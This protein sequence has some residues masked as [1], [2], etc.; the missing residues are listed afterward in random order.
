MRL[1]PFF[2]SGTPTYQNPSSYVGPAVPNAPAQWFANW[3]T[4]PEV[5]GDLQQSI[6]D[7]GEDV[8]DV[9]TAAADLFSKGSEAIDRLKDYIFPESDQ[10]SAGGFRPSTSDLFDYYYADLSKLYG[11]DKNTAFQEALSNTAYQ[12]AVKDMQAAGLNPASLFGGSRANSANGV[13]FIGNSGSSFGS[14][15]SN[16][17]LFES[18]T[19][20]MIAALSGLA[21]ALVTKKPQNFWLG[22]QAAQGVMQTLNVIDRK[23]S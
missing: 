13:S 2:G 17:K 7:V 14:D 20:G 3:I 11:M 19:Y 16:G 6:L 21:T 22:Q 12:R 15:Q 5:T 10:N 8:L 9:G 23:F 4:S 1:V 18:D